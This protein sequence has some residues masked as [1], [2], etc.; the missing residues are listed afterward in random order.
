MTCQTDEMEIMP[1]IKPLS[2][3]V[4]FTQSRDVGSGCLCSRCLL[5]IL[6]GAVPIRLFGE[7]AQGQY[8]LRYHP[9]C[10]GFETNN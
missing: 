1:Q 4:S 7:N 8:E 6:E 9:K 3:D 2:T 5:P 10:L